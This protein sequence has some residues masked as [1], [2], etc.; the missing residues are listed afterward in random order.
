LNVVR[1]YSV[2]RLPFT[3]KFLRETG[4]LN[5]VS[6]R[7]SAIL[8][9]KLANGDGRMP[10]KL[11]EE[12]LVEACHTEVPGFVSDLVVN[13]YR[14]KASEMNSLVVLPE[15]EAWRRMDG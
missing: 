9:K 7:Y 12:S 3:E 10:R 8:R 5:R 4:H 2:A 6:A 11:A 14:L 13:R 15:L 1:K